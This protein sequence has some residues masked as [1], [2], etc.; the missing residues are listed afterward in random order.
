MAG[1]RVVL[2]GD[3]N[4]RRNFSSQVHASLNGYSARKFKEKNVYS[5]E[6]GIVPARAGEKQVHALFTDK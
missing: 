6:A 1:V 5:W 2:L 3:F 4:D